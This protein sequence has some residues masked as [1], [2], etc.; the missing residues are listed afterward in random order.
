MKKY[1]FF[2]LLIPSIVYCQHSNS[3]KEINV[4]IYYNGLDYN[5]VEDVFNLDDVDT[6]F[7]FPGVSFLWGKTQYYDN[8][9]FF[10]YQVGIALPTLVTGKVGFGLGNNEST[11]AI[12]GGVRPFPTSIYLQL[13]FK[14]SVIFSVEPF[15]FSDDWDAGI[16]TL[17]FRF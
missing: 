16:I 4:G 12:S 10:D 3:Y 9:T 15:P 7:I 8:N 6:D 11:I 17:G 5:N 14:E 2:L 1:I 13:N